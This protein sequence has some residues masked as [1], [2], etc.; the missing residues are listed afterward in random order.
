MARSLGPAAGVGS[1]LPRRSGSRCR[2]G[3][4]ARR[5]SFAAPPSRPAGSSSW[6]RPRRNGPSGR[7]GD[8]QR[9]RTRGRVQ[10]R[11]RG[12]RLRRRR[13]CVPPHDARPRWP[14]FARMSRSS[15]AEFTFLLN[16][17]G[18][19]GIMPS[20]SWRR[21]SRWSAR[22]SGTRGRVSPPYYNVDAAAWA[23]RVLPD[24][25]G[26]LLGWKKTS[27]EAL[28][29]AFVA[30]TTAFFVAVAFHF[31]R[32]ARSSAS[33]PWRGARRF[34][35][36]CSGSALK[37]FNAITPVLGFTRSPYSTSS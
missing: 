19:L 15:R 13:A 34:T 17:H 14:S 24:G 6:A 36:A 22:A 1:R 27:T 20:S 11:G 21:R 37:A 12:R 31:A 18:L 2:P 16:N 33:P 4:T 29:R 28:R 30:P 25:H 7:S 26:T 9:P 35:A 8:E 3:S 5:T 10:C 32:S 23:H